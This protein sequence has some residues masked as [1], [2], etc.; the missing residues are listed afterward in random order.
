MKLLQLCPIGVFLLNF[1]NIFPISLIPCDIKQDE[2]EKRNCTNDCA[3][4]RW[5]EWSEWATCTA[6]CGGLL[7]DFGCNFVQ[8]TLCLFFP[9]STSCIY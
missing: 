6:T 1:I 3:D 2:E 4:C 9:L 8:G 7:P 5:E